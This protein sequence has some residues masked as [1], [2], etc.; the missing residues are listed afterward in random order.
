[1]DIL[2]ISTEW[3]RAELF[4]AKIVGLLSLIVLLTAVGF[5]LWGK[6]VMA[7]AFII[8]MIVAGLFLLAVGIGLYSANKPRI[9]QFKTEY[10]ADANSFVQKEIAR[11][12]KSQ[13]EFQ[14]VFKA[15]P[16][17][18]IVAVIVLMLFS[19]ANWRAITLTIITISAFLMI[20]DSNTEA[21]NN[22]Y[23]EQLLKFGK[24]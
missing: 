17:I 13:S 16:A 2:K 1:M 3:A 11:T 22:I 5:A 23:R 4:S 20:I 14:T 6:T 12:T 24:I 10:N 19:S 7:K 15:L 9:E 8:P 18:I 21:R